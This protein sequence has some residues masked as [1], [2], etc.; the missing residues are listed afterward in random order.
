MSVWS[1]IYKRGSGQE[2]RTEDLDL[3]NMLKKGIVHFQYKKKP[4]K[5]Y[6]NGEIRDAWGTKRSDI[7]TVIPHNGDCPPKSAGYTP[8]FDV[9]KQ[10][11]RNFMENRIIKIFPHIYISE[12]EYKKAY[13]EYKKDE[14]L[15][16]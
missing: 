3:N 13:E 2:I 4:S 9:E 14:L 1:E 5:K 16:K 6:P 10:D 7:I 8:Y 12:E 11:W 15:E